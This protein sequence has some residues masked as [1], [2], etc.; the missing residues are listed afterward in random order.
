MLAQLYSA[1]TCE[2]AGFAYNAGELSGAA[3]HAMETLRQLEA[4]P[5]AER[6][7]L[8]V[9]AVKRMTPRPLEA[10]FYAPGKAGPIGHYALLLREQGL[11]Y[12]LIASILGTLS[13][14]RDEQDPSAWEIH[15]ASVVGALKRSTNNRKVLLRRV[16]ANE[17]TLETVAQLFPPG[18]HWMVLLSA[19]AEKNTRAAISFRSRR[20]NSTPAG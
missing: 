13:P 11:E 4:E 20:G 9:N 6:S 12:E 14:R 3:T 2:L 7:R 10:G 17:G 5:T 15:R 8:L 16:F 18:D 19:R 1:E